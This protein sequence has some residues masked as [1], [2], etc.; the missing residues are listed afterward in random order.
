M[1]DAAHARLEESVSYERQLSSRRAGILDEASTVLGHRERPVE[2]KNY[3][4][5]E[6]PSGVNRGSWG[7]TIFKT[8]SKIKSWNLALNRSARAPQAA[9]ATKSA[10]A[11]LSK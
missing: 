2:W 9:S 1:L 5:M 7:T 6:Y 4:I 11:S 10:S 8:D 3:K